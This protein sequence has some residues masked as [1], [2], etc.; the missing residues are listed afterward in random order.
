MKRNELIKEINSFLKR[1]R[2]KFIIS[3]YLG[4]EEEDLNPKDLKFVLLIRKKDGI[5]YE[6]WY[7]DKFSKKSLKKYAK[8]NIISDD[9]EYK[10]SS[11]LILE[12]LEYHKQK[13]NKLDKI[14]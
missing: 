2:Y 13:N 10:K 8:E 11:E 9:S 3:G 1:T 12:Y 4:V 5:C 7:Y 6:D 14:K